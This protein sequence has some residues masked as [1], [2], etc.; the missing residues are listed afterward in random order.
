MDR[1]AAA[2]SAYPGRHREIVHFLLLAASCAGLALASA[3]RDREP[4][5]PR[6]ID[7][8]KPPDIVL[9]TWDTVRADAVG[10]SIAPATA[11]ATAPEIAPVTAE[12]AEQ[13]ATPHFDRLALDGVRFLDA[14]SPVPITLPAH[15]SL[16]SGLWPSTHGVRDNGLFEV[17]P[18]VPLLAESFERAGYQTGAFVS[19]AVL[20]HRYGLARGFA[21]YDDRVESIRGEIAVPTRPATE[22]VDAALAWL[23]GVPADR[24]IFLWV[25]LYDPHRHWRAPEPFASQYPDPYRA[26]I[27]YADAETGRLI[28]ALS[29]AGRLDSAIVA[30]TSDHGEGLGEHGEQTH[31]YFAYES[32]LRIPLVLWLGPESKAEIARGAMVH[33]PAS[34]VDLAPTLLELASLPPIGSQGRS[35]VDSLSGND[36]PPRLQ[37]VE[38][39]AGA[40]GFGTAPVFG[41]LTETREAW[42]DLPEPEHYDLAQDPQQLRNLYRPEDAGRA[43][44]L[45]AQFDWDWPPGTQLAIDSETQV[46]LEALGYVVDPGA[47]LVSEVDPKSRVDLYDLLM[48]NRHHATPEV[49]LASARALEQQYGLLPAL[50][51]FEVAMLDAIGRPADAIAAVE[52]ALAANPGHVLLTE[53]LESRRAD[54][55]K[56]RELAL[57]IRAAL[58]N[59]PAHPM[60]RRDLALTLHQIQALEEAATLYRALL[61]EDPANVEVRLNLA[62]L[63]VSQGDPAASLAVLEAAPGGHDRE[64]RIDCEAGRLLGFYLDRR[65]EGAAAMRRCAAAGMPIGEMDRTLLEARVT[66]GPG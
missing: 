37:P 38:C 5:S 36:V 24:P 19:A 61:E 20:D 44:A 28:D 56:K 43:A 40:F 60:A 4:D 26:E 30:L 59:D 48:V 6:D 2:R 22:V 31:A 25:H 64:P 58:A 33:G 10:T 52:R 54:M 50:A 39:V 34:L 17:A 45:F 11:P 18:D 21:H 65:D 55:R 51:R 42:Y 63:L 32:T 23:A 13:S 27:A 16:L 14:R 62:R 46:Q 8:S 66:T 57:A 35:L 47:S 9:V 1:R 49:A 12:A 29:Q 53:Q 3:C 15:T 41:V 7:A